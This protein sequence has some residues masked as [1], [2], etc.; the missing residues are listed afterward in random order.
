[1]RRRADMRGLAAALLAPNF[2]GSYAGERIS[3][4]IGCFGDTI[5]S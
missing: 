1:M 4:R 3:S 2:G 5:I